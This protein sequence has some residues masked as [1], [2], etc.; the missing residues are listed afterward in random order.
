MNAVIS[1]EPV[2]HRD[3]TGAW[4]DIDITMVLDRVTGRAR[5]ASAP[6]AASFGPQQRDIHRT[7]RSRSC[8]PSGTPSAR[9]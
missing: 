9:P 7:Q 5:T 1:E 8:C 4:I 2:H 6:V 3:D